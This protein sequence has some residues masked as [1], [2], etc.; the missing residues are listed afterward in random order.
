MLYAY[1]Y[2]YI[3]I[4][5]YIRFTSIYRSYF[6]IYQYIKTSPS[7]PFY[8]FYLFIHRIMSVHSLFPPKFELFVLVPCEHITKFHKLKFKMASNHVVF[9]RLL[10]TFWR[11]F[12][13]FWR[14]QCPPYL[15]NFFS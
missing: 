5:I 10:L 14:F 9:L 2:I 11:Y 1:L 8:C 4:Y 13:I 15:F 7:V 6:S 12:M 3:Y